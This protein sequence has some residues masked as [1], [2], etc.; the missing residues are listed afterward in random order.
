LFAVVIVAG[1]TSYIWMTGCEY[2]ADHFARQSSLIRWQHATTLEPGNAEYL[3]QLGLYYS[4]GL[5]S[6]QQALSFL[7]NA[8][9][10]NPHQA[11]YWFS[12]ANVYQLMGN[13]DR[14][15]TA[16]NRA[17]EAD[18]TT[19]DVA[20]EAANLYLVRGENDRALKE[21]RVV[22]A[23][24]SSRVP[25]AL[26][27]SWQ[28]KPDLDFLLQNSVP[29][30]PAVYFA[31][32]EFFLSQKDNATA[33]R[34]WTHLAELNQPIESSRV[35]EYIRYLLAYGEIDQARLVWRQASNLCG[36]SAY[37]PTRENLVVNGD[38]GLDMLNAGFDWRFDEIPGVALALDPSQAHSGRRSLAI[39][40]DSAGLEDTGIRQLIPVE[41]N[42]RYD[43][44]AYFK[45]QDIQGAGGP[46]FSIEDAATGAAYLTSD[47]LKD[48]DFW[49][50]V[51]GQFATGP[52][53]KLVR[54]RIRRHPAGSPIRGKLWI[55]GVRL[56]E[57]KN[58]KKASE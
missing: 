20:W 1:V 57:S 24:D 39:T 40:Y 23:S 2:L 49:K 3:H 45:A 48:A 36:L 42:T 18:P 16:L 52:E 58:D 14:Q 25:D 15:E 33:A 8:V 22:L 5:Q 55:D 9:A 28:I 6:P 29:A 37:Q 54:L 19:P 38:F 51:T 10:L 35:F 12:L 56:A 31:L 17:I 43:F 50:P 21:F 41:A 46:E 32:L 53:T 4:L 11:S 26:R 47:D 27:L 13:A 34:V 7:Q 30:D 44:A